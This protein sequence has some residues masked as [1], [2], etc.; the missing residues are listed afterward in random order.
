MSNYL[1]ILI[2]FCPTP[3][4]PAFWTP[5]HGAHTMLGTVL[6]LIYIVQSQGSDK[7]QRGRE[8]IEM[9]QASVLRKAA[10]KN[11]NLHNMQKHQPMT[12]CKNMSLFC[13]WPSCTRMYLCTPVVFVYFMLSLFVQC[14]N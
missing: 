2:S 10:L 13:S 12:M 7:R 11:Q 14:R 8:I 3:A 6:L 5:A 9:K 1:F 4:I